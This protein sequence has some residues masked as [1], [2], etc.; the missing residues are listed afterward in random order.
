MVH[1]DLA[2]A[3]TTQFGGFLFCYTDGMEKRQVFYIHGGEPFVSREAYLE[4]L[5]TAKLW[6]PHGIVRKKWSATFREDVGEDF[7]IFTPQMPNKQNADYA[8][9]KIWFERHVE[10]LRD[11][12]ILFGWSLGG[13]F[14]MKY[15]AENTLP[16]RVKHFI[17]MAAPF[18]DGL[19]EEGGGKST[20]SFGTDINLLKNIREQT[21]NITIMH[22]T[23][24]FVVPY[25]HALKYKEALPEAELVTFEDKN[26]FLVEDLPELIERIKA[27]K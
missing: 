26:H 1:H 11:G 27:L 25:E 12:V 4:N 22:S 8:E 10:F 17:C 15:L 21:K 20:A 2:E 18:A 19:L 13:M 16:V 9:W 3:V 24:D 6:D 14:L 7:E 5:R 23:D